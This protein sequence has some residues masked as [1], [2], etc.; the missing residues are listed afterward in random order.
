MGYFLH[1][2]RKRNP[3]VEE[4][5]FR[6]R[7]LPMPR[8]RETS[9]LV[10]A[11]GCEAALRSQPSHTSDIE[12]R[13]VVRWI[14]EVRRRDDQLC[15]GSLNRVEVELV[16]DAFVGV[17]CHARHRRISYPIPARPSFPA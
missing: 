1:R 2:A 4:N 3:L 15:E 7:G 10:L 13:R 5:Y 8:S 14:I 9:L 11:D 17:W 6:Y 16:V 12:A